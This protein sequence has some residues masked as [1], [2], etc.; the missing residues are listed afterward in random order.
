MLRR[1]RYLHVRLTLL[2]VDFLGGQPRRSQGLFDRFPVG[3]GVAQ[4]KAAIGSQ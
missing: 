3:G 1:A 4:G 2:D